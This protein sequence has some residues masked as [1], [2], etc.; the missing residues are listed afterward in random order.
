MKRINAKYKIL[1]LI[2]LFALVG[3][4]KHDVN[5]HKNV[6]TGII[7]FGNQK[8]L[9]LEDVESGQERFCKLNNTYFNAMAFNDFKYLHLDDTV[10]IM[11]GGDFL[12]EDYYQENV[13]LNDGFLG[14]KYNQDSI[15]A[16]KHREQFSK[17]KQDINQKTR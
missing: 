4:R 16:R 7:S 6:I 13:F 11:T 10:T 17:L 14:I 12:H 1:A 8:A 15:S 5:E 2:P 9:L 3:C